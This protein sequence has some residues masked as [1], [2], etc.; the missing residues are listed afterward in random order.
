MSG[1]GD[2]SS[3]I[4]LEAKTGTVKFLLFLV[5]LVESNYHFLMWWISSIGR[6]TSTCDLPIQGAVC[7]K[8][9]FDMG[10]LLLDNLY[11]NLCSKCTSSFNISSSFK[12]SP[13]L[14]G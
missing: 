6:P 3:G 4:Y 8:S 11:C 12:K 9:E 14:P 1:L 2:S 7:G 10:R 5:F 13:Y